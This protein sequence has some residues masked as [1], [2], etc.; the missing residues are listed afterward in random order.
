M[1][2]GQKMFI[3]ENPD[4]KEL[5]RYKTWYWGKFITIV[6]A[7]KIDPNLVDFE[8]YNEEKHGWHNSE[9]FK[10]ELK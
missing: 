3:R 8:E 1:K 10:K 7:K 9:E 4:K 6:E 2:I 5:V